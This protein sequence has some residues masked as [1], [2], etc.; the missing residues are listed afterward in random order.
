MDS[1][2]LIKI[3][4]IKFFY[5]YFLLSASVIAF[6]TNLTYAQNCTPIPVRTIG[7][8]YK[9][10]TNP[11]SA[12]VWI[13]GRL[14][15]NV[16]CISI[17]KSGFYRIRAMVDY[18]LGQW[19][20]SFYLEFRYP[21]NTFAPQL[22][23]NAGIYK[24]VPDNSDQ[25][26]HTKRYA[27]KFY[28]NRGQS[29]IVLNHYILIYQD[30][31]NFVNPSDPNI[32]EGSPES[33]HIDYIEFEYLGDKP[34][35]FDLEISKKTDKDT[36]QTEEV[37][38]YELTVKNLGPDNAHG[39]TV[40]DTIPELISA[41]N[42]SPEPDSTFENILFWFFESLQIGQKETITFAASAKASLPGP[43]NLIINKATLDATGDTNS[44]NNYDEA[45]V[46]AVK[47]DEEKVEHNCDL[48]VTKTASADT[49]LAGSE[50]E[51]QL[52][53]ENLSPNPAFNITLSDTLPEFIQVTNYS[54]NPDSIFD[55]I[56]QW[57]IDSLAA[58]EIFS[59]TIN[60]TANETLPESPTSIFNAAFVSAE[61]DTNNINDYAIVKTIIIEDK[62]EPNQNYDLG[63]TKTASK[64]SIL[65][66]E[67]FNYDLTIKNFGVATAHSVTLIDTLPGYI[68][69]ENFSLNPDST[70][71]NI[72][73]WFFDS[74]IVDE[75]KNISLAVIAN[76]SFP[77]SAITIVNSARVIAELDT[78]QAN[79]F[80]QAH[81]IAAKK[82]DSPGTDFNLSVS[83]TASKDSVVAGENFTYTIIVKN[84][85]P[86]TAYEI[87]LTDTLPDLISTSDFNPEPDSINSNILIWNIDSLKA[88]SEFIVTFLATMPTEL[89]D[90]TFSLTN[91]VGVNAPGD[92]IIYGKRAKSKII[93]TE[94]PDKPKSKFELG[95]TKTTNKDSVA[96]GEPFTYNLQIKNFGPGT[97][98]AIVLT[99]TLPTSITVSNF[100][101][102]PDSVQENI[103]FWNFDSL[104]AG[105][106]INVTFTAIV[107]QSLADS[108]F[109]LNNIIKYFIYTPCSEI[110]CGE[111]V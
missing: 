104:V 14:T 92:T 110:K 78:N 18:S 60:A 97:A 99:D 48:A 19:N 76:N 17:I 45:L 46:I 10:K 63:L 13:G 39:L 16:Q 67:Q 52:F 101:P 62:I 15:S 91:V 103:L 61:K 29:V 24:V 69:V 12:V 20:E 109:S 30:F 87:M 36:V 108:V 8:K 51:Y 88:N 73:F 1:T 83:K 86:G 102:H 85:G 32:S 98:F 41:F 53:V 77:D 100:N 84:S 11:D 74:V 54:L 57:S 34:K 56:I 28:L 25:V 79:N 6:A 90:S 7:D 96:V 80:D 5:F 3:F 93:V 26:S 71:Q 75:E 59:V 44:E 21:N 70:Y 4:R 64:D 55:N 106:E 31:P 105:Q 68:S 22:E 50:F 33:V 89:P 82:S 66:G 65:A 40:T 2:R 43:I 81:V 58:S 107:N 94:D 72:L 27:G 37:F 49:V 42:F 35:K 23:P 111:I 38:N 95:L 9:L 47:K